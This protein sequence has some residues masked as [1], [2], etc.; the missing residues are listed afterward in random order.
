MRLIQIGAAAIIAAAGIAFMILSDEPSPAPSPTEVG[1]EAI[2]QP[3]RLVQRVEPEIEFGERPDFVIRVAAPE[4]APATPDQAVLFLLNDVQSR[5]YSDR[6]EHYQRLVFQPANRA[7]ADVMRQFSLPLDP[8]LGALRIHGLTRNRDG[9]SVDLT[10]EIRHDSVR[11]DTNASTTRLT[12]AVMVLLRLP[13]SQPGDIL[14]LDFTIDERF[15]VPGWRPSLRLDLANMS[16]FDQIHIRSTWPNAGFHHVELGAA[17]ALEEVSGRENTVLSFGPAHFEAPEVEPFTP[18]W[19]RPQPQVVATSFPDWHAVSIWGHSLFQPIIDP[20]VEQIAAEIRNSTSTTDEQVMAALNYVQREIDYFAISL[21]GGG[22]QP[23]LPAETLRYAE[24]DCKA[25]TLLMLSILQALGIDAGAALVNSIDGRGLD[26]MP[27]TPQAFDHVI[28]TLMV[29]NRRYWLDPTRPEQRNTLWDMQHE[30]WGFALILDPDSY[31]LTTIE[32]VRARLPLVDVEERFSVRSASRNDHQALLHIEWRFRGGAADGLRVTEA[33]QGEGASVRSITSLYETRFLDAEIIGEPTM[34]DVAGEEGI[35]ITAD[36]RIRLDDFAT[37]NAPMPSYVFIAHA[38]ARN[39]LPVGVEGRIAP[40]FLPYPYDVRHHIIVNLPAGTEDWVWPTEEDW[41]AAEDRNNFWP[42]TNATVEN[43]AFAISET[44]RTDGLTLSLT[45]RTRILMP[46][47]SPDLF[48]RA[49]ND[50]DVFERL[51]LM[52][53]GERERLQLD[54]AA[55]GRLT[56]PTTGPAY[57]DPSTP[58]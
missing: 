17:P 25:K 14:D 16:Q 37:E 15:P 31:Q 6:I 20:Q 12:G 50:L 26:D 46:E 3:Q 45:A 5:A 44:Y 35:L 42:L 22:Y 27:P 4:P 36:L 43:D 57:R 18:A 55:I 54:R 40:L 56:T 58:Y 13:Q 19:R 47:L 1:A 2:A 51:A 9:E 33:Y 30:P 49:R 21:G 8:A 10:S 29:G 53:T 38:A 52:P 32:P 48:T 7:G 28:V 11:A 39:I 41:N 23:L 24:G 34:E